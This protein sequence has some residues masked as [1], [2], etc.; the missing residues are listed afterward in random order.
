MKLKNT[1]SITL[2]MILGV[3]FYTPAFAEETPRTGDMNGDQAITME[4]AKALLDACVIDQ[5]VENEKPLI[6]RFPFA[7]INE[8]GEITITDA[9]YIL[10][11]AAYQLAMNPRDML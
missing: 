2:A 7:D 4:D 11:Y 1:I 5:I 9:K 3:I 8:D 10:D 6:E